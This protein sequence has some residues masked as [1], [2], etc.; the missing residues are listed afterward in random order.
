M[1]S[2]AS[3]LIKT[4][5]ILVFCFGTV[6]EIKAQFTAVKGDFATFAPNQSIQFQ[7]KV[8]FSYEGVLGNDYGVWVSDGTTNG[9]LKLTDL[10]GTDFMALDNNVY[11]TITGHDRSRSLWRSDGTQAGTQQVYTFEHSISPLLKVRNQLFFVEYTQPETGLI[12][13]KM[14]DDHQNEVQTIADIYLFNALLPDDKSD[15]VYATVANDKMHFFFRKPGIFTELWVSDGTAGGTTLFHQNLGNVS[16]QMFVSGNYIFFN[17]SEGGQ[18]SNFNL[19]VNT[20]NI[21]KLGDFKLENRR[22]FLWKNLVHFYDPSRS[23]KYLYH[24]PIQNTLLPSNDF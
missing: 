17:S 18:Y 3:M 16:P 2:L 4:G 24:D 1:K 10:S 14:V 21:K 9:T 23:N 22:K 15:F 13:L 11:F 7:N 19:D 6:L 20:G 8:F 12:Q 5:C